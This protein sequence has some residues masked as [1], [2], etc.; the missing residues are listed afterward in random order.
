MLA[1]PAMAA[2]NKRMFSLA[3]QIISTQ[4]Q[5]ISDETLDQLM[6]LKVWLRQ[7]VIS[8]AGPVGLKPEDFEMSGADEDG[9]SM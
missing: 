5:S 6:C 3:K 4:R 7:N 2:E 9:S 8:L 1:I